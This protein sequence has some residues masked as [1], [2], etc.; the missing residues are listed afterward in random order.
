MSL[1]QTRQRNSDQ[2]PRPW[3]TPYEFMRCIQ[4][5]AVGV[6]RL[7]YLTCMIA[8]R[9]FG[10]FTPDGP[11]HTDSRVQKFTR[12][13]RSGSVSGICFSP[14]VGWEPKT[15]P[16]RNRY[17]ELKTGVLQHRAPTE[18]TSTYDSRI[19]NSRTTRLFRDTLKVK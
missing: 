15:W 16:S 14:S 18:R 4:P 7:H 6:P 3:T 17:P 11:Y 8:V 10:F 1:P 12:S 9:S 5:A 2:L 19:D 13:A